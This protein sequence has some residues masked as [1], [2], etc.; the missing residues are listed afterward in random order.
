MN[1]MNHFIRRNEEY[2]ELDRYVPLPLFRKKI[3]ILNVKDITKVQLYITGLG[4]YEVHLNGA[5]ITKGYLAPYRSNHDDFVYYDC[6][7]VTDFVYETKNVLAVVLGNG[8]QNPIVSNWGFNKAVWRGAPILSFCLEIEYSNGEKQVIV[9]NEQTKTADS[10]IV[11]NDL[12]FGEY[13]DARLELN[14]WDSIEFDDSNWD[15]AEKAPNPHGE[16]RLCNVEP[17]VQRAELKPVSI[18]KYEDGYIYDFGVNDAGVCKL[19][20]DGEEGQK[21]LLQHF[22]KIVDGK[23]FF[24]KAHCKMNLQ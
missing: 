17:I 11:F 6:Y 12:H 20:I 16:L 13:Y 14:D 15:N 10:P 2:C 1:L 21:I 18:S 9:S 5:N 23:P 24:N 4:F 3:E 7:D 8:F 19:L 22:E